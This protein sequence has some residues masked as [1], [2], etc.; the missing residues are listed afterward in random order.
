MIVDMLGDPNAKTQFL[1]NGGTLVRKAGIYNG[2]TAYSQN[3]E[4]TLYPKGSYQ[5]MGNHTP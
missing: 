5:F 2:S 3:G 4:Y 1:P